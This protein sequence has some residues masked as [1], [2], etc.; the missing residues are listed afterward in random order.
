MKTK[1]E[2]CQWHETM[3]TKAECSMKPTINPAQHTPTPDLITM[4]QKM[5]LSSWANED[6]RAFIVRAVNS[7]EEL[8]EAIHSLTKEI[9]LKKL[10]IRKD[11][12]LI[13]AYACALK[14][15]AKAEGKI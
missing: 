15:L 11:F 1:R 10:N 6:D 7:H 8:L 13:N 12:S 3:E 5:V 9:D 2:Y 4:L 14:T